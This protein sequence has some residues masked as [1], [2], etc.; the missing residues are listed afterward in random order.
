M[1]GSMNGQGCKIPAQNKDVCTQCDVSIWYQMQKGTYFKWCKG[2]KLFLELSVSA[3]A[4]EFL[5]GEGRRYAHAS[6]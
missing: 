1:C 4:C 5:R 3:G 6:V 2:C